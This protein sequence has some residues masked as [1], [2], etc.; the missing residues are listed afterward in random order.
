M[1][2]DLHAHILTLETLRQ[3]QAEAPDFAPR[4]VQ[5]SDGSTTYAFREMRYANFPPGTWDVDIRLADMDS[6]GIDVQALSVVPFAFFYPLPAEVNAVFARIQNEQIAALVRSHPGRFAGLAT[7]PMQDPVRAE[8]E[9]RHALGPLGLHGVSICTHVNG[10]NLDEPEFR[11]VLAALEELGGL[12]ELHPHYVAAVDR[13]S[14]YY[15]SNFIGNPLESTIAAGSLIFGGVLEELPRLRVVLVHGGG[16]FPYGAGR[17]E[18]GFGVR[19]EPHARVGRPP[20]AYLDRFYFDIITHSNPALRYLIS[21]YGAD[22][23]VIGTDYPF[24]MGLTEPVDVVDRL[25][26]EAADRARI[27]GGN[28]ETLLPLARLAR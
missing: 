1:H 15:L 14:H 22:H 8:E 7:L 26:L 27:L 21:T 6:T 20:S 4:L 13:L 28:A 9:L 16:Y 2:V 10:R 12:L 25:G 17:F 11:P 23:V 3:M 19:P 24:D 5:E 18:H